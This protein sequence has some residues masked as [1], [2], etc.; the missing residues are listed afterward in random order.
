MIWFGY[1]FDKT[2]FALNI[3]LHII[4]LDKFDIQFLKFILNKTFWQVTGV[5]FL[6]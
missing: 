1:L 2:K 6:I 5:N 3:C 4:C